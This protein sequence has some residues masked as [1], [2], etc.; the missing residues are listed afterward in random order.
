MRIG[1]DICEECKGLNHL[2]K[3]LCYMCYNKQKSKKT[4]LEIRL[5]SPQKEYDK[6]PRQ[7]P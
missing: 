5:K 3:G 6:K 4:N 2:T 1:E 7:R